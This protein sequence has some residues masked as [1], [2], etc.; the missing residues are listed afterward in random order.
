[1]NIGFHT[2][3]TSFR[4][5]M[6]SKKKMKIQKTI[7]IYWATKPNLGVDAAISNRVNGP[8]PIMTGLELIA[9]LVCGAKKKV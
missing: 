5:G 1:M 3:Q 7:K 9:K 4:F 6:K 2:N 8:L